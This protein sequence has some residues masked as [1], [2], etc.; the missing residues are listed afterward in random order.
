MAHHSSR[1]LAHDE[2]VDSATRRSS[3]ARKSLQQRAACVCSWEGVEK[4]GGGED[5]NEG[6]CDVNGE[7]KQK[8]NIGRQKKARG[9]DVMGDLE[10]L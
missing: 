7:E 8:G 10:L 3:E 2:E 4:G 9:P 1:R 6:Q 5:A